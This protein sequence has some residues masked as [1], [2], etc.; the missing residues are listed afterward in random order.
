MALPAHADARAPGEP[1]NRL[2]PRH[3]SL[4]RGP[5][6]S[7]AAGGRACHSRDPSLG[8]DAAELGHVSWEREV[9][10]GRRLRDRR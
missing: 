8:T 6:T 3:A 5:R 9:Q 1:R 10:L 2:T 4:A 7:G